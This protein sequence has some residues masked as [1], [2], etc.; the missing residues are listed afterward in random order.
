MRLTIKISTNDLKWLQEHDWSSHDLT[1]VLPVQDK[2]RAQKIK[3]LNVWKNP[4]SYENDPNE[5]KKKEKKL[6]E[7]QQQLNDPKIGEIEVEVPFI[8]EM[9]FKVI[10]IEPEE[11]K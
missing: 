5:R 6:K 4:Y 7:I 2:T 11:E 10:K 9:K 1:F 3:L 8:Y